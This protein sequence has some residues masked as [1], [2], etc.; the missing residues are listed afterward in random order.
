MT[1]KLVAGLAVCTSFLW[2]D[3]SYEQTSKMTGGAMVK[4][5]ATFSKQMREPMVSTVL[6][7]GDRM[8]HINN[9]TATITDLGSQTITTID[10]QKQTYS[11]VTFAQMAEMMNSLGQ[12]RGGEGANVKFKVTVKQTGQTRQVGDLL[13][14]EAVMTMEMEATDQQKSGQGSMVFINDMWLASNVPGYEEVKAF[15]ERMAKTGF[16]TP[17]SSVGGF[18]AGRSDM[19]KGMQE[20]SKEIAKMD[21][22]PVC[23]VMKMTGQGGPD[24]GA[25]GQPASSSQQQQQQT[26]QQEEKP[27]VGSV[28]GGRFGGFGGLGRRKKQQDQTQTDQSSTQT[29]SQTQNASSASEP[30]VLMEVTTEMSKFSSA[31]VD[32]SKFEIP[33]GFKQVESE[34][35]KRGR[36]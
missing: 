3:F 25:S 34:T 30:G 18:G 12:K 8:A 6:L 31:P 33:A 14:K 36:R 1:K 13:A 21:G 4:M 17:N 5:M 29:Q 35:L 11:V 32:G 16:W 10:F 7:K 27:S 9:R 15:Y 26:Q 22:V 2:A 28:L 19:M 23:I 24:A 20:A